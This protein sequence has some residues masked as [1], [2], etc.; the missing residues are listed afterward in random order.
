M[1]GKD[2]ERRCLDVVLHM[3]GFGILQGEVTECERPDF[4][5][6][7]VGLE[8]F[9]IDVVTKNGSIHRKQLALNQKV[10]AYYGEH[11]NE[12][13]EDIASG[14]ASDFIQ[15][16][17]NEQICG[18]SNFNYQEFA[19]NFKRVFDKHYKNIP[20]YRENCNELGF[21]IE[22]RCN[23][24]IGAHGYVVTEHN[25]KRN[26]ALKTIPI[27]RDMVNCFK[28]KN[29]VDF[30]IVCFM[31]INFDGNYSKCRVIKIDMDNVEQSIREQGVLICD[32]FN[33]SLKFVNE[34]V[35]H[36][37]TEFKGKKRGKT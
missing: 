23:E 17:I 5:V 13:N 22:I 15:N 14:K 26:Q 19:N 8:H 37:K 4:V 3:G 25:R 35:V 11:P 2:V 33:Y 7:S 20:T 16:A 36:L 18:L 24:P 21:L 6:G 30:I 27:T 29:N 32:E 31:P 1:S 10:V 28:Q 34:D 12:L 9:L